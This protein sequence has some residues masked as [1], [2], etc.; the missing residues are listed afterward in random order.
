MLR[1]FVIVAPLIA[2]ATAGDLLVKVENVPK[3]EGKVSVLVF[4]KADG[5]PHDSAQAERKIEVEAKAGTTEVRIKDLPP[6]KYAITALHDVNGNRKLD[7][8]FIGIPK[9]GVAISGGIR[10]E[11]PVFDKA[12]LEIQDGTEVSLPLKHW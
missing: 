8:N 10:R 6:G 9:E 5:F 3:A 4:S 2:A 7:R 12:L 1:R 11:R